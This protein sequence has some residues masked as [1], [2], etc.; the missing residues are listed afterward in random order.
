M[1]NYF[2]SLYVVK[3]LLCERVYHKTFTDVTLIYEM[4]KTVCTNLFNL[5]LNLLLYYSMHKC[6]LYPF[7]CVNI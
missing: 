1:S 5:L 6:W 2:M 7:N 3:Y 4:I